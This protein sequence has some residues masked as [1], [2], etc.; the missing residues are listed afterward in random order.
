MKREIV[1]SKCRGELIKLFPTDSPYP[2]EHIKFVDGKARKEFICDNCGF[3][4]NTT[5]NCTAMSI[6]ADHGRVPYIE[7]EPEYLYDRKELRRQNNEL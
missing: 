3:N 5:E 2:M 4:I 6:W 1:C 7:W